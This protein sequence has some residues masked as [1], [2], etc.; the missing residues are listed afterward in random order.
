MR[1]H[2]QAPL[3]RTPCIRSSIIR[4]T[5]CRKI[6]NSFRNK[7]KIKK[8]DTFSNHHSNVHTQQVQNPYT[9]NLNLTSKHLFA[10]IIIIIALC[11]QLWFDKKKIFP[12]HQIMT[13]CTFVY[14]YI[15][16]LKTSYTINIT[17]SWEYT[18]PTSSGKTGL[19]S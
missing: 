13:C 12:H 6:S 15:H 17:I 3:Y 4:I 1:V 5:W 18:M 2:L 19:Y 10:N 11:Y 7:W 8:C 9:I 14:R 16:Q